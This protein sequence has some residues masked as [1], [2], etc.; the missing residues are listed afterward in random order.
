[1]NK[2]TASQVVKAL[3]RFIA[4]YGDLVVELADARHTD[5]P[6]SFC[7]D[8]GVANPDDVSWH[9]FLMGSTEEVEA[10]LLDYEDDFDE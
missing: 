7:V 1:M 10:E 8:V 3:Q 4:E 2:M 5:E 9:L 6:N